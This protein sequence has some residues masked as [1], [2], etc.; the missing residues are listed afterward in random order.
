MKLIIEQG[1]VV[2][3][4]DILADVRVLL[5]APVAPEPP[6]A[7]PAPA[8]APA[9]TEPPAPAPAPSPPPPAPTPLPAPDGLVQ[10]LAWDAGSGPTRTEWNDH[11]GLKWK[12]ANTGDWLDKDGDPQGI[13]PYASAK[14]AGPG[15]YKMDV[16]ALVNRAGNRGIL[17]RTRDMLGATFAGRLSANKPRLVV[18]GAEVPLYATASWSVTSYAGKDSRVRFSVTGNST[19]IVQFAPVKN[20]AAATLELYCESL[21]GLTKPLVEVFECDPP[22]IVLGAGGQTPR[23]GLAAKGEAALASDPDVLVYSDWSDVTMPSAYK[24]TA[25]ILDNPDWPGK[26]MRG[27]FRDGIGEGLTAS[28]AE[29]YRISYSRVPQLNPADLTDPLRPPS[30]VY[31]ELF[32]RLYIFLE[33]DWDS[34]NDG[35]KMAVGWDLRMGWWKDGAPGYWQNTTGN[36]GIAGTGLKLFAP[37]GKNGAA[38]TEDRWEYQG[39]SIRMEAGKGIADGNPY[40]ELRPLQSYIYSLDQEGHNGRIHR[41]GR[42]CLGKGRWHCVEQRLKLNSITGPFDADGN[43]TAMPDGELETWLDGVQASLETKLR[44]KRHHELGIRGPWINWYYGG[45]AP[46]EVEMHYRQT[47]LVVA[48]KYIGPR[49]G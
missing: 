6:P 19:A 28:Q 42:A 15:W 30:V 4:H 27:R 46:S 24:A 39:H 2:T 21:Q 38:Q 45:K 34:V 29:A 3:E 32:C 48:R 44:F 16:T 26:M 11:L 20:A 17:L 36:G 14:I 1:A 33:D 18:D 9:P 25:E 47:G 49:V 23:M 10:F 41:L 31:D 22:Q 37:A 7:P 35:N 8:P 43:G 12:N 13:D 40:A 5:A